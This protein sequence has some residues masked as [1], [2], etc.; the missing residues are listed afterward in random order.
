MSSRTLASASVGI[1]VT[2]TPAAT[3]PCLPEPLGRLEAD[4][5][6]E[7]GGVGGASAAARR[8]PGRGPRSRS[9]PRGR[10]C[11]ISLGLGERVVAREREVERVVHQVARARSRRASRAGGRRW[12]RSRCRARR[13]RAARSARRRSPRRGAGATSGYASSNA[14]TASGIS[15]AL[16]VAG[17]PMCRRPPSSEPSASSWLWAAVRRSRIASAWPT[18][19]SPACVRRTPRAERSTRRVPASASSVAIWRETAGWVNASDSA[20]AEKEPCAATSRRTLQASDVE[21]DQSVYQSGRKII[22]VYTRPESSMLAM[23]PHPTFSHALI[24]RVRRRA[25]AR[26]AA[27]PAAGSPAGRDVGAAS[28]DR[29]GHGPTRRGGRTMR[30]V[31]ERL[32]PLD[33]SFLHTETASAHMHVAWKGRFSPDPARPPITLARVRA[34]VASRL[35]SAPRFRMRLAFP[36]GGLRGAGVGRRRGVRPAPPRASRSPTDDEVL[37]RADFDA[38]A[39]A[40]LSLA[41]GPLAP[42]V[43]DPS[44]ATARG[45]QRRVS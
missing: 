42:A 35:G 20:A 18:S 14:R 37:A 40:V 24:E 19:S 15:V 41:A 31:P 28:S 11:R 38:R 36:P 29:L 23:Q 5:R 16:A 7:A 27:P 45:R 21:H 22:C 34:Q 39:D 30:R 44:R 2:P 10:P 17:A 26:G 25:D 13:P 32:T 3:S 33:A 12:R 1:S 4:L 8:T 9:R 6:L 43:G